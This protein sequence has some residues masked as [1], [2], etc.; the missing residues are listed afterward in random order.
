MRV[1]EAF[2]LIHLLIFVLLRFHAL[3]LLRPWLAAGDSLVLLLV[4]LVMGLYTI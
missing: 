4:G 1:A 3:C 2:L